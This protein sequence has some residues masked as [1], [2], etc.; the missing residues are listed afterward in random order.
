MVGAP[1]VVGVYRGPVG[2]DGHEVSI[3]A[4]GEVRRHAPATV[5]FIEVEIDSLHELLSGG[6]I[7]EV[8]EESV[9]FHVS[10]Q[11]VL[12]GH[13]RTALVG[14]DAIGAL[15]PGRDGG[16]TGRGEIV[17]A[18]LAVAQLKARGHPPDRAGRMGCLGEG[19]GAVHRE[20]VAH[21]AEDG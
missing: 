19:V 16:T 10:P 18:A 6:G 2:G 9:V 5:V 17:R 3:G 13:R 8:A 12:R 11:R 21:P 1:D 14:P 7:G 4:L 20:S 15:G